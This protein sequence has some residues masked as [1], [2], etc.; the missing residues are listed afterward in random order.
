MLLLL[1]LLLPLLLLRHGAATSPGLPAR[2]APTVTVARHASTWISGALM[3]KVTAPCD[4]ASA[5][6]ICCSAPTTGSE[7]V[8]VA[9]K[10]KLNSLSTMEGNVAAWRTRE[11]CRCQHGA[12]PAGTLEI[13]H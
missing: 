10:E 9:K 2:A 13:D 4:L 1:P 5:V 12:A 6:A 8:P 7:A 11:K 3:A